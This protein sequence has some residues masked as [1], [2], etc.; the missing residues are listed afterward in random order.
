MKAFSKLTTFVII[1]ILLA[2]PIALVANAQALED[3]WSLRGYS[4]ADSIS[5]LAEEDTMTPKAEHL[6]YVTHPELI[7]D[8]TQFR[9]AC[10]L[11]EQT[12]VLGCYYQVPGSFREG[13]AVFDVSDTRLN[14]V[15]EVTLGIR[16]FKF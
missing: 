6:F 2:I 15:E 4:P 3:W 9:T 7:S 16:S 5:K 8:K 13:I 12:I 11:A 14:G 10:P 1:I